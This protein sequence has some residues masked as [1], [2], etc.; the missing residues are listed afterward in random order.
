MD[1]DLTNAQR[2]VRARARRFA[3]EQIDPVASEI[4]RS[5]TTPPAILAALGE[6]GWLGAALPARWGGGELDPLSYG[7]ATEEVGRA[8]SSVRSLM[9]VHNMASQALVRFGSAEQQA[10]WLP[11]LCTGERKIAFALTEPEV[12]SAASD[13]RCVAEEIDDA[14]VLTGTK[15]WITY[16]QVADLFLVIARDGDDPTAF[17]VE[18]DRAGLSL[19][20]IDDAFGTRGSM[21]ACMHLDRLRLPKANRVGAKGAG[22]RFVANSVLDHG[23]F[24]VA[25]GATAIVRACLEACT[26]YASLREQ[27]GCAL[28]EHQLIRRQLTDMLV[29]DTTARALCQRSAHFR[30]TGHPHAAAETALAKYHAADAAQKAAAAAVKIHGGNGCSADYPV[31]RYLRDATVAGII[32]GTQEMHQIALASHAMRK[33]HEKR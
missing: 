14:F 26:A 24:S 6:E 10:R 31:G 12:G 19:E 29:L 3:T 21:L 25:W 7:L 18:R 16:G 28:I 9:T 17:V 13:I 27:G 22:V 1:L 15:T 23:R 20:P 5:Q 4:D 32:E 2:E 11:S 30:R 8:C 33:A